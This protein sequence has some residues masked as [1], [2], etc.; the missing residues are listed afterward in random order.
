MSEDEVDADE[1]FFSFYEVGGVGVVVNA[2]AVEA[3]AGHV[4]AASADGAVVEGEVLIFGVEFLDVALD[5]W[6]FPAGRQLVVVE[7]LEHALVPEVL[8]FG[9]FLLQ[10]LVVGEGEIAVVGEVEVVFD[11]VFAYFVEYLFVLGLVDHPVQELVFERDEVYVFYAEN[12]LVAES[13]HCFDFLHRAKVRLLIYD[14]HPHHQV[15]VFDY[16]LL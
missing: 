12:A 10:G 3:S 2:S 8:G 7:H 6:D 15:D 4:L 1:D 11:D 13:S 5:D 14:E 9:G 16:F